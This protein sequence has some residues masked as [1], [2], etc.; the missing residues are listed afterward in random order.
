[1]MRQLKLQMHLTLDGFAATT[2]S[3]PVNDI[4]WDEEIR[5]YCLANLENV[6]LLLLGHT[7]AKDFIPYWAGVAEKPEDPQYEIG[8][9]LTEIPKLVFSKKTAKSRWPNA[10]VANDLT[11][12]N[13]LKREKGK[14]MLVY[15]GVGFVTCLISEQLIDEY[16][17]LLEPVGL[18]K[19]M[20]IF[21]K[22]TDLKLVKTTPFSSGLVVLQYQPK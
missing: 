17:F 8:K 19:G 22:R 10:T 7:T 12:I 21:R 14:A 16:N 11:V 3:G 13:R 4:Y 5:D 6:D 18:G 15:G 9:R 2:K 1:M 20:P